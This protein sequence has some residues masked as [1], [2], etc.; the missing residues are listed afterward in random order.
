MTFTKAASAASP[1]LGPCAR[2]QHGQSVAAATVA[3]V[4][5]ADASPQGLRHRDAR[6]PA[7]QPANDA[8][9]ARGLSLDWPGLGTVTVAHGPALKRVLILV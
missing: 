8:L 9:L 3:S 5:A 1:P 4:A 7:R 6:Q 2:W